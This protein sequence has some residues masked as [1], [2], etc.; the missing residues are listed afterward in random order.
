MAT[1]SS[2]YFCGTAL[3][4]PV[5]SGPV[6]PESVPVETDQTVSLCPTCRRKL[7]GILEGAF[8][9][10]EVD[11]TASESAT[12]PP[13][14]WITPD[15][16]EESDDDREAEAD[17]DDTDSDDTEPAEESETAPADDAPDEPTDDAGGDGGDGGPGDGGEGGGERPAVLSTPAAKQVI[18]LLQNR[19]FP[20]ER[21]EF[22]IVAAN[23]YDI[24]QQDCADVID[25]LIEEDYIGEDGE[26]LTREE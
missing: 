24:P 10:V 6:V 2:C 26:T 12:T 19:E 17:D 9:A 23:A 7:T 14:E 15:T 8:E 11:E 21:T 16:D 13:D 4:A 22:E 18:R 5:E 20:L 25:A 3:D 1:L